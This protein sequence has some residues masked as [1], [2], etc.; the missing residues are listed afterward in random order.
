MAFRRKGRR[1]MPVGGGN[2]GIND[3]MGAQVGGGSRFAPR[4]VR[5]FTQNQ[6]MPTAGAG[7]NIGGD[8]GMMNRQPG[9]SRFAP[10]GSNRV[11]QYPNYNPL[12]DEDTGNN[13]SPNQDPRFVSG[14]R[15]IKFPRMR[16]PGSGG[17]RVM[18]RPTMSRLNRFKPKGN[19]L[20]RGV[21]PS[22]N[23]NSKKM[24]Y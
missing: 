6:N 15:P 21:F 20:Q 16:K 11:G 24:G 4:G 23:T 2:Q 22:G 9:S 14:P 17:S 3:D 7:D 5:S 19:R 12:S 1:P 10:R 13:I 18:R 8:L